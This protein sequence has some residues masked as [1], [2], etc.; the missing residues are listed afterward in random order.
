MSLLFPNKTPAHEILWRLHPTWGPW[1]EAGWAPEQLNIAEHWHKHGWGTHPAKALMWHQHGIKDPRIARRY[2][3]LG[4]N[5]PH[6]C[7]IILHLESHH[8][9]SSR[10][11]LNL[12]SIS[13]AVD[14]VDSFHVHLHTNEQEKFKHEARSDATNATYTLKVTDDGLEVGFRYLSAHES[15]QLAH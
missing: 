8:G 3:Q 6:L 4:W 9:L 7:Q 10:T 12:M 15:A 14:I 2:E 1:V 11:S 13:P 5:S